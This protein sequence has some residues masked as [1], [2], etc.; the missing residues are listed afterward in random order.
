M[1][2][3]LPATSTR[4]AGWARLLGLTLASTLSLTGLGAVALAPAEAAATCAAPF[5]TDET[6]A[7]RCVLVADSSGSLVVPAG[8]GDLQVT[9]RGAQG[10]AT[11]TGITEAAGG[12]GGSLTGTISSA[13][14]KNLSWSIGQQGTT[15]IGGGGV[16]QSGRRNGSTVSAGNGGQ[17][18]TLVVDSVLTAIAGGGGG[19]GFSADVDTDNGNVL[20][21]RATAAGGAGAGGMVAGTGSVTPG[22]PTLLAGT[23]AY[24]SSTGAPG[25]PPSGYNINPGPDVGGTAQV[26]SAGAGGAGGLATE[27]D[28]GTVTA[29]FGGGG[30]GGY[31]GGGGGYLG[32]G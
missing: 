18:T 3:P 23:G 5:V 19:A 15:G 25:E 12:K 32:G 29:Y 20:T 26:G 7:S 11:V 14:G 6:D 4:S 1:S 30:G 13:A 17:A 22:A 24:D 28:L 16:G 21:V 31:A 10:G 9:V 8:V 2:A 27:D